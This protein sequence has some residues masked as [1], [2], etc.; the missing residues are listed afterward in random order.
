MT[1]EQHIELWH[2]HKDK[3]MKALKAFQEDIHNDAFWKEYLAENK[4]ANKHF[5]I[6]RAMWTKR[7]KKFREQYGF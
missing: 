4:I 5:G 6:A 2:E 3:A 7:D 1:S